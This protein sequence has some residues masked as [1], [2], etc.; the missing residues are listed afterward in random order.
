MNFRNKDFDEICTSA[1]SKAVEETKN[2]FFEFL[3]VDMVVLHI[4]ED[5]PTGK[6]FAEKIKINL[7]DLRKSVMEHLNKSIPR[8]ETEDY[9][10]EVTVTTQNLFKKAFMN[11][12]NIE[13]NSRVNALDILVALFDDQHSSF[14][15]NHL[16]LNKIGENEIKSYVDSIGVSSVKINQ[17]MIRERGD[18]KPERKVSFLEK[19]AINLSDR[20]KE[21]KV[22]PLI[23]RKNVLKSMIITLGQKKKNNPLIV[24]DAG[25]GKTAI[26][27]G[28]ARAIYNKEQIIDGIAI[29]EN[30][31]QMQIFK[32]DVSMLLAGAKYRG[33]FEERLKNVVQEAAK[34]KNCI[35]FIDDIHTI[36]NLGSI[37]GSLDATEIMKPYL[38][39]GELKIIGC[40]T[41]EEYRKRFEKE[42]SFSR[43]F[44]VMK[45]APATREE[46]FEIIKG[47]QSHLEDFHNVKFSDEAIKEVIALTDKHM[48]HLQL[49]DKAIDM[50][51]MALSRSNIFKEVSVDVKAIREII[52]NELNIP[53]NAIGDKGEINKLK[54]LEKSLNS[55]VFGQPT[56][57]NKIVNSIIMNR[58]QVVL[59]DKPVGSFLLAGPTGV[60]KTEICK[61]L[62]KELDIPL[63][64]FDMSE[65][66]ESHSLAKL[67]GTAPGYTGHDNGGLLVEEITKTPN[68]VLLLDEIEKAHSNIYDIL[69]QIM[70]YASV[71]DGQGRKADFKNVILFMTSNLGHSNHKTSSIGFNGESFEEDSAN[72]NRLDAIKK[73][74]R[75]EF[76]NRLDDVVLFR[77]LNEEI[78]LKVVNKQIKTIVDSL[79]NK[80]I[81]LTVDN[82]A[83]KFI[84]ENGFD[85]KMGARN[86]ERFIESKILQPLSYKILFDGLE[87]GGDIIISASNNEISIV[88]KDV[89]KSKKIKDEVLDVSV[90][91]PA[92][93]RVR[94][95]KT[96]EDAFLS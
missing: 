29:P 2:N 76:I 75:P 87:K 80:A 7:K 53:I 8:S 52:A 90:K 60:G 94:K 47:L 39:S 5:T 51:D 13:K 96:Q 35:L 58:A 14:I 18:D 66:K 31:A 45:I 42:V 88:K 30:V 38:V 86:V 40:T 6:D 44:K 84:V 55:Q 81:N 21:G 50:L 83:I 16:I 74:F 63:I 71:T 28:L 24:G 56:A 64:R 9:K 54:N 20:A 36:V 78:I 69:L 73:E 70:D 91:K 33:D 3:A 12:H 61:Q 27:E 68:C 93:K 1:I 48:T 79:K 32:L 62:A 46:T 43:L 23:G 41:N 92:T 72:E 34:N 67:I 26:V 59:K 19:Y 57:V 85:E 15:Y 4:L 37:S 17:V 95:V 11:R 89:P 22:E 77:S 82:S 49:P 65:Y 10:V 25:V